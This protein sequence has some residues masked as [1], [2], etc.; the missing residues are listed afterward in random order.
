MTRGVSPDDRAAGTLPA[1]AQYGKPSSM[2]NRSKM[3]VLGIVLLAVM[4]GMGAWYHQ[5]F[6]G[7]QS[8]A[9]WGADF[10]TVIRH[11][12]KV[13]LLLVEPA[14]ESGQSSDL[15]SLEIADA[16]YLI[17]EQIDITKTRGLTHARQALVEDASFDW[18]SGPSNQQLRWQY[19]LRF[20]LE[21]RQTAVALDLESGFACLTHRNNPISLGP[22]MLA[23]MK[24]FLSEQLDKQGQTTAAPSAKT[25]LARSASEGIIHRQ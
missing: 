7:D 18:E 15:L 19:V 11:A 12:T 3:L 9:Y 5:Y 14:N 25:T 2:L 21:G 1:A 16:A 24:Y 6:R 8:L 17:S 22:K 4:A 13:E 23:G 20:T 10:T